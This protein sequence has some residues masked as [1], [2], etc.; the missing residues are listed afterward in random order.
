MPYG[1][2]F[3]NPVSLLSAKHQHNALIVEYNELSLLPP[4]LS[5]MRDAF[6]GLDFIL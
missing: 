1:K 4:F 3:L 2:G 5:F 6:S